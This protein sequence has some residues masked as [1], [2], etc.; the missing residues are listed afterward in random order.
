MESTY[1]FKFS[2]LILMYVVI[3]VIMESTYIKIGILVKQIML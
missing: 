1:I 2:N 3:L